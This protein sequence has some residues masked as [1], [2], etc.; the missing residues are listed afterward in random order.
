[1][2]PEIKNPLRRFLSQKAQSDFD[3]AGQALSEKEQEKVKT[4]RELEESLS[5]KGQMT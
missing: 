5:T 2:V 3:V 1:M 4:K